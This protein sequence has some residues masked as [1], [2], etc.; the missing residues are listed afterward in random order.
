MTNRDEQIYEAFERQQAEEFSI[1]YKELKERFD[2]HQKLV[3]TRYVPGSP[4]EINFLK[5]K[6]MWLEKE[7]DNA[8]QVHTIP[9][10]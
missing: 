1:S 2:G 3:G 7:L 9:T 10:V 4:R 6:I 5:F 8:K